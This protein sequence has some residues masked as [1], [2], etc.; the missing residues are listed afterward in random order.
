MVLALKQYQ[1]KQV[2]NYPAAYAD[3]NRNLRLKENKHENMTKPY[4]NTILSFIQTP[5]LIQSLRTQY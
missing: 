2:Q 3:Y 1:G 5:R 4:E